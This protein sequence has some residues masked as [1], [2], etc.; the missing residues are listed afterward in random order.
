MPPESVT[1]PGVVDRV[2][3]DHAAPEPGDCL[4]PSETPVA[5]A[6]LSPGW[7]AITDRELLVYHPERQPRVGRTLRANVTGLTVRRAGARRL[8]DYVPMAGLFAVGG[9]VVGLSLLW[10][11]PTEFVALPEGSAVSSFATMVATLGWAMNTLGAVLV[12]ASILAALA[13]VVVAGYWLASS[14]VTLVVERGGAEG[15]ECPTTLPAGK[16]AAETMRE[17]LAS[18]A[19]IPSGD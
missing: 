4:P 13:G 2:D 11:E 8:L 7:V 14:D 5:R 1:E 10:V 17:Q 12:F 9:L 3:V 16:R 19:P 18:D 15:L 6:D